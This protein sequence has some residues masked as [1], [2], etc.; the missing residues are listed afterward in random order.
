MMSFFSTLE[1]RARQI[2]SLLCIG[3]DPH[4]ADL[5]EPTV[6]GALSFCTTLV[7]KTQDFALAYKPNIAF[8]EAFGAEGYK[9]LKTLI[10]TIP[11]EIPVI[12]DAKRGD[13]ASTADAYAHSAFD[14]LGAHAITLNPYLGY[15]SLT[16]FI[17][18]PNHGAFL[19]CKTSNPGAADIQDIPL[20][21]GRPVYEHVARIA[22]GW[23]T[24]DNIGLVVG[25][26]F[27]SALK[28]VRKA[29]PSLWILS[30]GVGAQ[31]GTLEDALRAGLRPDGLGMVVS[32]S[33]GISRAED[34]RLAAENFVNQINA[35]RQT[36]TE[37]PPMVDAY[38]HQAL[39]K[40]LYEA[41][42]IKFGDFTL[43]SGLNSPIYI[44]LRILAS[45]PPLLFKVATA[46]YLILESL[47]FDRLAAIPYTAIPIGTAVSLQG[48]WPLIYPRKEI[49][50]Y[51]TKAK[52]EG[53]YHAGE[54]IAIIDDLTTTGLSKF[55]IIETLTQEDLLIEDIVVLI[56]RESGA[57]EKL[58]DAG[59][60]LHAVFTLSKLV[61]LL[62]EQGLVSA[63][64]RQ[65]VEK[66]IQ[67]T[68]IA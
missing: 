54:R 38:Q 62:E 11:P 42:C 68:K 46:Y 66:F 65:V 49:K 20:I 14:V 40:A 23:N 5:P 39:A 55:E 16:P 59:Y 7:E 64:Q 13:I 3:L 36:W 41:E 9:A 60:R 61:S 50:D 48:K 35:F 15:D 58:I 44:D 37:S 53:V 6:E 12:L 26:T 2:N 31:G 18:D 29:A 30:P 19:V 56:D 22:R 27:P 51:G 21:S 52:I 43:K 45:H 17:K 4:I 25:A 28:R 8:F 10:A 33:R 63:D 47:T 67:E 1:K 32:I 24:Q 57:N 34:P